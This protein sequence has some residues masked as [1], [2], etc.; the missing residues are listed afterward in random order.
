MS[1]GELLRLL[2]ADG[3]YRVRQRGS[4]AIYRHREKTGQLT[5][6]IHR[7]K[8]VPPGTVNAILKVAGLK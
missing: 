4:H 1:T 7:G 2:E 8:E 6:P 3:W 5:V